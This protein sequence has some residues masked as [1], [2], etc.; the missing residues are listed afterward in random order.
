M[1]SA[2]VNLDMIGISLKI[3][4]FG[5]LEIVQ[6]KRRTRPLY[7]SCERC[8]KIS[9]NTHVYSEVSLLGQPDFFASYLATTVF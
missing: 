4:T 2:F 3:G 7:R 6:S 5:Y 1:F 9:Q 8:K